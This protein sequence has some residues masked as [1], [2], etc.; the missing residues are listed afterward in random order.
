M[1]II[2]REIKKRQDLIASKAEKEAEAERLEMELAAL[3]QAI[4][5]INVEVLTAEIEELQ[6][7]LDKDTEPEVKEGGLQ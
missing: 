5:G 3:R 1:N 4:L 7:Y 6:A 2:E